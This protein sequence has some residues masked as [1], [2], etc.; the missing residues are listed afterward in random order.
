[1]GVT[2]TGSGSVGGVPDEPI[3]RRVLLG[4]AAAVLL[5]GCDDEATPAPNPAPSQTPPD[6][7][8]GDEQLVGRAARSARHLLGA[9]ASLGVGHPDTRRT[10]APLRA[11]LVEHLTAWGER[12]TDVRRRPRASRSRQRA[13]ANVSAAERRASDLRVADAVAAESGELARVLASV[14]AAHAQHAVMLEQLERSS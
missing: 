5:G 12:P 13:I 3:S 11:H 10:T 7:Q 2:E 9:Y 6:E 1:V 8:S 4:G 14:A